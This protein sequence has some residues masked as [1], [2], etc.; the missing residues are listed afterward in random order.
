MAV[1]LFPL[2]PKLVIAATLVVGI[3]GSGYLA[4]YWNREYGATAQPAR[5]IRSQIHPSERDDSSDTYRVYERL[6][7]IETIRTDRVL[8]VGFGRPF[9]QYIPL[10]DLSKWWSLQ[11]YT[12]H[13]NI[14]WLWLKMGVL[15]I[16]VWLGVILVAL[17][18]CMACMRTHRMDRQWSLAAIAFTGLLMF[19]IYSTVDLAFI[20]P[21]AFAPAP[22]LAAVAFSLKLEREEPT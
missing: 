4:A 7:A 6:N 13:Q 15:G 8:G 9:I 3:V 11:S 1:L 18:R 2:R 17:Q 14:L 20:G 16:S 22:I 5:A 12:P 10:P 21:R 19:L